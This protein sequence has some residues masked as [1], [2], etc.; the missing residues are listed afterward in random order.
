MQNSKPRTWF[1]ILSLVVVSLLGD[2]LCRTLAGSVDRG[3]LLDAAAERVNRLPPQI[4]H[5]RMTKS[6]PLGENVLRELHCR[7][8]EQRMYADDETGEMVSVLLLVGAAG[9]MVAHTPE[10]CYSS[11]D[12]EIVEPAHAVTVRGAA[13]DAD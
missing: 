7:T 9:P 4:G 12:F 11:I 13:D 1:A 10:R 6:E 3:K 8:Y 5:W 2:L